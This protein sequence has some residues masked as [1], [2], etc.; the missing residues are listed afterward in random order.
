MA[1][2]AFVQA[3][4]GATDATG[5]FTFTG[6]ATGTI[7]H[8]VV[9]HIGVD[10]TGTISWGTISGTN[11][12]NLAGTANVWTEVGIFHAGAAI[13][14][15]IFLG[16][17]TSATLAPT[18]TASAN[19]SG[20]D[21]Y[22]RMYEFSNVNA[23]TLL[24]DVIENAT[25]GS[26][27]T[28]GAT[29]S[30][31]IADASVQTLGPD[32]LAL[33]FIAINDD[34]AVNPMAGTTSGYWL[35]PVEEYADS[36]GT[37]VCIDLQI[38]YASAIDTGFFSTAGGHVYGAGGVNEQAAQSFASPGAVTVSGITFVPNV[39]G[40]P[41]DNLIFEIQTDAAGFPSGTV[42]GTG[43]TVAATSISS[44]RR[45]HVG[46][47]SATLSA[48]TTYWL[49][50]RRDGARDTVNFIDIS[51]GA[52]Y[53]NGASAKMDSGVWAA[54]G[55]TDW[56]FGIEISTGSTIDGGTA[57]NVD[58]TDTWGVVGFALIGTTVVVPPA[59][60][61]PEIGFVNFSDPGVL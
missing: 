24:S 41:T 39:N 51:T 43:A 48:S 10:G 56:S 33:N 27:T 6:V 36:T 9:M 37:D 44:L 31:T 12:N 58:A 30:G 28:S 8:L 61:L 35:E 29:A 59:T 23:E 38:G 2:P 47:L 52:T 22:G 14:Q 1:A 15:R 60:L 13:Q 34:N 19:T 17:R 42:V 53:A 46:G 4:T 50:A 7:G 57:T 18:F 16:R 21:V 20:D 40:T 49:V 45:N 11:I 32:R 3:S 54:S 25:A 55:L 5:T 26:T